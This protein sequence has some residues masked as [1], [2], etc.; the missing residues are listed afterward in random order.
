MPGSLEPEE[1]R[2]EENVPD[3]EGWELA[4]KNYE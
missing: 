3:L 2:D 1:A 4:W